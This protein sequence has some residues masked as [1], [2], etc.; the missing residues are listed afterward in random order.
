[1]TSIS[2]HTLI[3][4]FNLV[5]HYFFIFLCSLVQQHSALQGISPTL[6]YWLH[7][8]LLTPS[9][10]ILNLSAPPT[11]P[12]PLPPLLMSTL[13]TPLKILENFSPPFKVYPHPKEVKTHFFKETNDEHI[14]TLKYEYA[15]VKFKNQRRVRL[16]LTF[17]NFCLI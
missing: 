14:W 9:K 4:C 16:P 7:P 13:H 10:T 8:F 2:M 12:P 11:P 17:F 3:F 5:W 6:K 15:V 1:M